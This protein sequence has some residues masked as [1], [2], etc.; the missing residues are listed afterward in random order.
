MTKDEK[1]ALLKLPLD[2]KIKRTITDESARIKNS[3]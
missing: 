2:K 1:L 3:N